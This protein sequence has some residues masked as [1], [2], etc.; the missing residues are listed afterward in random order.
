MSLRPSARTEVRRNRYKVAVD[1][2]EGRRR[3]EDNMVEI[4]KN[5]REE[6]LQKKRREGRQSQAMPASLHSSAAE[7]KVLKEIGF[8]FLRYKVAV[9]ADEGRRRR[10]D[11]MVEI[12]KNRREESLQKKRREGRQSQ[13]MPASLHSSAAEKKVLKEIGF[14]F[15]R[16]KVAVDADEGRRRREDNMVE[17]RKN[18]REESLQK[19]RR[20]GRQSQAMPAS[21]HSSAAEKKVL[22]EIGFIFLR[23]KVAEDADEGR[24]RRED[25]MVEIRKNRREESL[26]KKRR[27]GLQSQAMSASLHSSAAEK[28]QLEHLPSMVAGVWSEDGSLQLEATTQF[29]KLLSVGLTSLSMR[30]KK[31]KLAQYMGVIMDLKGRKSSREDDRNG[32]GVS[33]EVEDKKAC[34]DCK[35]TKTPLW[36]GGPAG[37]KSLCNACGIR[38][39]KKR[40][41]MRLE[42]G[43]EKKRE[44]T[45]SSNT[46]SGSGLIS[47]SL[48]MSLMSLHE[49]GNKVSKQQKNYTTN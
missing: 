2:D 24:R 20:E 35:T 19:K 45:T 47:E 41:M 18:R 23:Y 5:R 34:T 7:K 27:E 38:Y 16:Y 44:K 14:I 21:L 8:I 32:G 9:D 17:I 10:E 30:D 25:N 22:K 46:T 13:A 31:K 28:K 36:R 12:R 37:P 49:R 42:K 1:A 3:R 26:Q 39:R 40:T 43:P 29:R 48:R 6:S 4:R 33:G 15:L 11:N